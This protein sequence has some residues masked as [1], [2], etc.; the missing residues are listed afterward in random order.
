MKKTSKR[1]LT[2]IMCAL[3]LTSS[4]TSCNQAETNNPPQSSTN[5]NASAY[6]PSTNQ[7]TSTNAPSKNDKPSQSPSVTT[8]NT[9]VNSNETHDI[10]VDQYKEQ[11]KYYMELT[12]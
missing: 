3:A 11:I 5:T 10:S 4:L 12:A 2:A 6:K 7:Q 1:I 8:P 9:S